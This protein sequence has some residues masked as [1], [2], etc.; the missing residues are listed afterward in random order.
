[1]DYTDKETRP[2]TL[3]DSWQTT[4]ALPNMTS[5]DAKSM[6]YLRISEVKNGERI[7]R[8]K[9][10]SISEFGNDAL[11][12]TFREAMVTVREDIE[13]GAS[14]DSLTEFLGIVLLSHGSGRWGTTHPDTG[15]PCMF[16]DLPEDYQRQVI[17]QASERE[18]KALHM[19]QVPCRVV[20]I[21]SLSG[22]LAEITL[23]APEGEPQVEI[24]EQWEGDTPT[25]EMT[26]NGPI[27][28]TLM[29][30]MMLLNLINLIAREGHEM[31]PDGMMEYAMNLV[32]SGDESANSVMSVV[33]KMI[34]S[35]LDNGALDLAKDD[36]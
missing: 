26:L 36:D 6:V 30:T 14:R 16:S 29:K 15:E 32:K 8:W 2:R 35:A 22:L 23:F 34:A 10:G 13:S 3:L 17:D 12:E 21:I 7:S 1:M 11:M 20:N 27:E 33:L 25:E 19:A 18:L 4:Y 28:E 24:V 9:L 31:T 5:D